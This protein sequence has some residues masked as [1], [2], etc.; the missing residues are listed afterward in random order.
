[1]GLLQSLWGLHCLSQF[2]Y[3]LRR[4]AEKN[5]YQV[6]KF[7]RDHPGHVLAY[8][9]QISSLGFTCYNGPRSL[10]AHQSSASSLNIIVLAMAASTTLLQFT[11]T[12]L[13][14]DVGQCPISIPSVMSQLPY[15]IPTGLPRGLQ[16][17]ARLAELPR[18]ISIASLLASPSPRHSRAT[19]KGIVDY[20]L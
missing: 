14:A 20:M 10:L 12:A 1:M 19:E 8:T 4:F 16:H 11:S 5:E 17:E 3:D 15:G 7:A 2:L 9:A 13:L 18:Q 6:L